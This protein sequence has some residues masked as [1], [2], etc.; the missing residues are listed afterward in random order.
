MK[1]IT[2]EELAIKYS[3]ED[4]L[5]LYH[6]VMAAISDGA[7][8]PVKA[9]GGNGKKPALYNAYWIC[10]EQRDYGDLKAELTYSLAPA[11]SIDY[12][13]KHL[14][15]YEKERKSVLKLSAFLRDKQALL[16][17]WMSVNERSFEIWGKEKFLK[18]GG[19]TTILKHCG[20]QPEFLHYYETTEPMAYYTH[21]REVPQNLLILENKD[22]FYSMRRH[23]M[24]GN[25][26]ILGMKIGTLIYGA[27]KGILRSFQ[28][29]SICGEPYM[30]EGENCIYYLGDLDYEGIGIYESL[31][32]LFKQDCPIVPFVPG[33]EAMVMKAEDGHG[34]DGNFNGLP[35]TKEGQ[36]RN[37]TLVFFSFFTENVRKKMKEILETGHYIP[38]EILSGRDF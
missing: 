38:Q 28:D 30:Q 34:K 14:D 4:Y 19:G 15:V 31:A 8:K 11:I 21:T 27:G 7:I 29:F 23:L 37:V 6:S 22:T 32:T 10:E 16:E 26:S 12:Y 13:L 5:E 9:S 2:L 33:Y 1:R 20:I 35:E 3:S 24:E 18:K 36:N 25:P 17:E